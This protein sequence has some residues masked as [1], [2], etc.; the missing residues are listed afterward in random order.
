M[1]DIF[2]PT[3]GNSD[4]LK[5]VAKN[6]FDTAKHDCRIMF[7]VEVYD[8]DSLKEIE[9]LINE[10]GDRIR[11]IKNEE[12][13]SL[14]ECHNLAYKQS[15]SEFFMLTGDDI[16][17]PDGW[18]RDALI[19]IGDKGTLAFSEKNMSGWGL[20]LIRRKYIEEF[21]TIDVKGKVFHEYIHEY[22]D[23]E[24]QF[25]ARYRKQIVYSNITVNHKDKRFFGSAIIK[26]GE[27]VK[28]IKTYMIRDHS[29]ANVEVCPRLIR[30]PKCYKELILLIDLIPKNPIIV[31]EEN[32]NNGNAVESK[33]IDEAEF[34]KRSSMW[35]GMIT[36]TILEGVSQ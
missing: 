35:G 24:F 3:K 31:N 8:V 16:E 13:G 19:E 7:V 22:A 12:G 4:R 21:G 28:H 32:F 6:I 10:Y 5:E 25:T 14:P 23:A 17:F 20:F 2:L 34:K 27:I 33:A 29:L 11:C 18:L 36:E 15:T 9:L 26:N 1:V 30:N